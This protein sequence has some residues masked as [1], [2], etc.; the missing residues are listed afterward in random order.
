MSSIF[1]ALCIWVVRRANATYIVAPGDS[2]MPEPIQEAVP[3]YRATYLSPDGITERLEQGNIFLD[4]PNGFFLVRV[5]DSEAPPATTAFIFTHA[6]DERI[7]CRI[8]NG[9]HDFDATKYHA[10]S[11]DNIWAWNNDLARSKYGYFQIGMK[12]QANLWRVHRAEADFAGRQVFTIAAVV[13]SSGLPTL[14]LTPIR[15]GTIRQQI[16]QHWSELA[17]STCASYR[18]GP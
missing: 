15:D 2:G 5:G 13:S 1:N 14:D 12:G 7:P 10:P 11:R 18:I 4:P 6:G 16:E 8:G 9:S 17:V 3:V